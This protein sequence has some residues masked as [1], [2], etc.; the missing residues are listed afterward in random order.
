[1]EEKRGFVLCRLVR[2][3]RLRDAGEGRD[4]GDKPQHSIR[5][6]VS[7]RANVWSAESRRS[8]P[9]SSLALINRPSNRYLRSMP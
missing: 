2:L 4:G 7:I 8:I 9:L 1:M 3:R 6:V 5:T